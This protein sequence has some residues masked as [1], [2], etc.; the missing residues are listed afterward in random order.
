MAVRE[1]QLTGS[2]VGIADLCENDR[3]RMFNLLCNYF[4]GYTPSRF[5]SDLTEKNG[6]VVLRSLDGIIRGFTTFLFMQTEVAGTPVKGAFSGDT[7]I[8]KEYRQELVLPKVWGSYMFSKAAETPNVP[9]FW[10]LICSGYKTYRYLRTFFKDFYPRYDYPPFD[11][12]S[13]PFEVQV[14]HAFAAM[15]FPRE[16]DEESGLIAFQD[17]QERLKPDTA[18]ITVELLRNKDVAFF[19]QRNPNHGLGV[20]LACITR[21]SY[22]NLQPFTL[23]I[24]QHDKA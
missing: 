21:M 24:L 2:V 22:E 13:K 12:A 3:E 18:P 23:R 4:D 20:E 9:F 1:K 19:S 8:D 10:F 11:P 6:A 16:Y 14:L 7:I 15:K 5:N 17:T